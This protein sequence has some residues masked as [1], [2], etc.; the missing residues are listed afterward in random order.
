MIWANQKHMSQKRD[1]G[2]NP[3]EFQVKQNLATFQAMFLGLES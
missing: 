3:S 1:N 2:I